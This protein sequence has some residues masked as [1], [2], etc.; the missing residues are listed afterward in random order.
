MHGILLPLDA[1]SCY[2]ELLDKATKTIA[3]AT[4]L[5]PLVHQQ[6]LAS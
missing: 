5:E 1:P 4:S 6:N 2:L 3:I